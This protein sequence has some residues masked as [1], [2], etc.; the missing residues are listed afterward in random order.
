MTPQ[1][2]A[3]SPYSTISRLPPPEEL[4]ILSLPI[5]NYTIMAENQ[6]TFELLCYVERG[7]CIV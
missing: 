2:Q 4:G 3:A 1:C 7:C 6:I 5:T